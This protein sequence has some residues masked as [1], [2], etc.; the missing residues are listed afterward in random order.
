MKRDIDERWF[1]R[2]FLSITYFINGL[3][4]EG[5]DFGLSINLYFCLWVLIYLIII[6][7][8]S[9]FKAH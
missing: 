5:F 7:S 3:K 9:D 2:V 8:K 6:Y 4:L 1:K